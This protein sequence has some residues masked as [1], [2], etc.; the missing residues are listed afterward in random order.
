MGEWP[1]LADERALV[2]ARRIAVL[3][4][5]DLGLALRRILPAGLIAC[6]TATVAGLALREPWLAAVCAPGAIAFLVAWVCARKG[7]LQTAAWL[8][9]VA[10][11][12]LV[13]VSAA[14]GGG[15]SDSSVLAYPVIL[16]F[17][18]MT[19]NGRGLWA[20]TASILAGMAFLVGDQLFAWVPYSTPANPA[21][22]DALIVGV[23]MTATMF[24]VAQLSVSARRSLA[25]AQIEIELRRRAEEELQVLSTHDY[26]TGLFNRRFFDAEV[27]RL[28]AS[29]SALVSAIVADVDDLKVVND[30]FGHSAGDHLMVKTAE[31]LASALRAGDVLA[32]IGGDEFAILLPDADET[33]ALGVVARIEECLAENARSAAPPVVHL[34]IGTATGAPAQ[35][36]HTI[37]EADTRMYANKRVRKASDR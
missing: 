9:I 1:Q 8:V 15:L 21:W 4:G 17:A 3:G 25:T 26:L 6:T 5:A 7:A 22:A 30:R 13:T 37:A 10:A 29:R 33:T 14:I 23:I 34:S 28:R 24:A 35:L 20:T 12:A 18:A 36:E 32:R 11:A 27:G 19:L 2:D 16:M 31:L